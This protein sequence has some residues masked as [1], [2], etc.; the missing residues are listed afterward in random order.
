M[1][2]IINNDYTNDVIE[3]KSQSYQKVHI[4]KGRPK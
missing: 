2:L 4:G 1:A 3:F